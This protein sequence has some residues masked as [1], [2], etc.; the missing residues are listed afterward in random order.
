MKQKIDFSDT[1]RRHLPQAASFIYILCR[2][3][4]QTVGWLLLIL[5]VFNCAVQVFEIDMMS[6]VGTVTKLMLDATG[7]VGGFLDMD[8]TFLVELFFDLVTM[9]FAL[10]EGSGVVLMVASGLG[11]YGF[12]FLQDFLARRKPLYLWPFELSA[13]LTSWG[14]KM[15]LTY[16]CFHLV[17]LGFSWLNDTDALM[18]LPRTVEGAIEFLVAPVKDSVTLSLVLLALCFICACVCRFIDSRIAHKK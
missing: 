7:L 10:A 4:F 15:I 5:A 2:I 9:P 16:A 3:V 17:F 8:L 1:L 12:R 14:A 11:M 6:V 18:G 13:E